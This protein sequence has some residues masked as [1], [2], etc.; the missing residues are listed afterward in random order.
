M[1]KK[2]RKNVKNN[3]VLSVMNIKLRHMFLHPFFTDR[4]FL[5]PCWHICTLPYSL[6][7]NFEGDSIKNESARVKRN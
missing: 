3:F 2:G 6:K 5:P 1:P 7:L 4:P